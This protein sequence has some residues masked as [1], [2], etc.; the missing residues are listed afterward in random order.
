MVPKLTE[1]FGL[2]AAGWGHDWDGQRA[3]AP[4]QG[5]M[6]T[7]A[8]GGEGLCLA[9]IQCLISSSHLQGHVNTSL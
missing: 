7:L 1:G 5:V 6:M 4:G 2:M 8:Y 9:R 3:A